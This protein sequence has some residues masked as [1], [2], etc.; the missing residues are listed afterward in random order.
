M[1]TL[2]ERNHIYG[3]PISIDEFV[4]PCE[5]QE[6][7]D[8]AAETFED[9]A[10]IIGEVHQREAVWSGEPMEVNSD[11]AD[12]DAEP[13]MGTS[14][15]IVLAEKLEAGYISRVGADNIE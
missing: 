14:E 9:D 8:T 13:P 12:C 11:D 7:L 3:T 5:E 10:T 6:N 2:K 1:A 4:D 15:L